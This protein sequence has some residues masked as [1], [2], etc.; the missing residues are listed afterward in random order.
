M[1]VIVIIL[2][3]FV[4]FLLYILINYFSNNSTKLASETSLLSNNVIVPVKSNPNAIHLLDKELKDNP[5]SE[6]INWFNL[7][8]NP[9]A[10]PL[11]EKELQNNPNSL[12]ICWTYLST[13]PNAIPIL[14]K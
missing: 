10:I 7:S 3:I 5:N 4:V 1:N 6:K 13:N 2:S 8:E 11:L 14:E 12:K 9:Y